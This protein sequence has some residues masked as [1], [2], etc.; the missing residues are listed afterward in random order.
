VSR[1]EYDEYLLKLRVPSTAIE[2]KFNKREAPLDILQD[3]AFRSS[4]LFSRYTHNTFNRESYNYYFK[5]FF[6][7]DAHSA[8]EFLTGIK[9]NG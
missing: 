1:E 3:E 8:F 7:S 6:K 5:E 9:K 2:T 4:T